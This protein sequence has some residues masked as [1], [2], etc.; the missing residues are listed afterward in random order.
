VRQGQ[1]VIDFKGE[2]QDT[3]DEDGKRPPAVKIAT[4]ARY[5]LQGEALKLVSG[6]NP[7]PG[8]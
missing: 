2:T 6:A 3:P 4:Q 1:V 7:V 8:F 5:A